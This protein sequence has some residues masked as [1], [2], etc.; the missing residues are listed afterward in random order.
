MKEN[1]LSM[2]PSLKIINNVSE[3]SDFYSSSLLLYLTLNLKDRNIILLV[4]LPH[5]YSETS[6]IGP[7]P[8]QYYWSEF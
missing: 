5:L 6:R 4:L 8:K 1:L 3:T 7:D 2:F